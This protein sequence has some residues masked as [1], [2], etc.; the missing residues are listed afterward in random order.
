MPIC[1]A[2]DARSAPF[3]RRSGAR[4][5]ATSRT[6][7][8]S[9]SAL[10]RGATESLLDVVLSS[11]TC[12]RVVHRCRRQW[13][14]VWSV[15]AIVT[16]CRAAR[17]VQRLK[18]HLLQVGV[19]GV[20]SGGNDGMARLRTVVVVP[21]PSG[22]AARQRPRTHHLDRPGTQNATPT[23]SRPDA[24]G[25][26]PTDR[27]QRRLDL[28]RRPGR[29]R[30]PRRRRVRRATSRGCQDPTMSGSRSGRAFGAEG[31]NHGRGRTSPTSTARRRVGLFG[32][33]VGPPRT[34]PLENYHHLGQLTT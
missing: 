32:I 15:A 8:V 17:E 11:A 5:A 10:G 18:P 4:D 20:C 34:P 1:A 19:Q 26:T 9:C 25:R 30:R 31:A 3:W 6:W 22:E 24:N 27:G 28:P 23:R 16:R 29:S 2:H 21:A 33:Q 7:P 14:E 13:R 12:G